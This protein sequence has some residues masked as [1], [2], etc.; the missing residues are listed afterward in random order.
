MFSFVSLEAHANL[1]REIVN[2]LVVCY[3][4]RLHYL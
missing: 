3:R 4:G 1:N 2:T